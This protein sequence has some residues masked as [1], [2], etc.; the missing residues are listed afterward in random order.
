[1]LVG[2]GSG[3][4]GWLAGFGPLWVTI[5]LLSLQVFGFDGSPAPSGG[6]KFIDKTNYK[7]STMYTCTF[8]NLLKLLNTNGNSD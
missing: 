3:A 2:G 4:Q 5:S 1:M 6:P 7:R 8:F